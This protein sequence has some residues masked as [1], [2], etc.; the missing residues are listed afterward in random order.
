MVGRHIVLTVVVGFA[1]AVILW[2]KAPAVWGN[3]QI[4]GAC[5]LL[6]GFVL[7]TVARFQLGASFTAT[8]QARQL[9]THGLYSRL[10]NPVYIFGSC[11]IAGVI[12]VVGR[13]VWLLVFLLII[14]MQIW[15][16]RK[17]AQVLE[18]KFGD[19]YRRYR[20]GTWF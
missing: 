20:A 19:E 17:E 15:R 3:M 2:K 4:V 5:L 16:G 1:A 11:V 6:I 9:V 7:W 8:A 12:L 10:R 13:P 14:P 18:A